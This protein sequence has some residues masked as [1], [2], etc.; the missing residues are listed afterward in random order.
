MGAGPSNV[1]YK[2]RDFKKQPLEDEE[3]E[4]ILKELPSVRKLKSLTD[5]EKLKIIKITSDKE[6][7]NT[8]GD[9]IFDYH[10]QN[11]I[12]IMKSCV[13]NQINENGKPC[14]DKVVSRIIT[15]APGIIRDPLKQRIQKIKQQLES[16]FNEEKQNLTQISNTYKYQRDFSRGREDD[17]KKTL[18]T[19]EREWKNK[20]KIRKRMEK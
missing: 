1:D 4:V 10:I 2:E 8:V 6:I 9:K 12:K 14:S 16:K 5:S 17:L 3:I 15:K 11:N 7:Y 13:G 18:V 19:K 20:R